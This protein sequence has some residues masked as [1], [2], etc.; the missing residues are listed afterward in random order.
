MDNDDLGLL[1]FARNSK[2][3]CGEDGLLF[4][5]FKRIGV[6]HKWCCEFGAWDGEHLSNS[7]LWINKA[8]WSA[9]LLEMEPDTYLE[10]KSR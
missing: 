5:I 4:E 3:Q 6:K 10:L 1:E 7:W 8:R 2:S 9:V